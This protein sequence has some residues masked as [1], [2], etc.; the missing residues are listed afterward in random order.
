MR[1]INEAVLSGRATTQNP[2]AASAGKSTTSTRPGNARLPPR[3]QEHQ[4]QCTWSICDN[5]HVEDHFIMGLHWIPAG[6]AMCHRPTLPR[7][8]GLLISETGGGPG[9]GRAGPA[10]E[11]D[12]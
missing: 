11:P 8:L 4:N 12:G 5:E 1:Q 7:V 9:S 2:H 10:S 6:V 3:E